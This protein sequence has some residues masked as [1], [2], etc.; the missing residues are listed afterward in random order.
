MSEHLNYIQNTIS[1]MSN[2]SFLLKGWAVTLISLL[3]LLSIRDSNYPLLLLSLI[4]IFTFWGLDAYYLRQ[5]RLFRKLYDAVR[6][7]QVN[8]PFSM[9]TNLFDHLVG[10]WFRILFSQTVVPLYLTIILL[11]V[12]LQLLVIWRVI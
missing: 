2:N 11:N 4:P 12:L 10:G 5:E 6:R 3:F 7:N 8:E 1:R 9:N